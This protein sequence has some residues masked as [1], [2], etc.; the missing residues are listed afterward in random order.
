[1]QKNFDTT[2]QACQEW[3]REQILSFVGMHMTVWQMAAVFSSNLE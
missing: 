3:I 1:M 2:T